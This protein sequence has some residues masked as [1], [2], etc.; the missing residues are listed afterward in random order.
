MVN[1]AVVGTGS[2]NDKH[3]EA[4]S[5]IP[6][7]NIVGVIDVAEENKQQ[8][9]EAFRSKVVDRLADLKSVHTD[10]VDLCVPAN[11]RADYVRQVSK[12]GYHIICEAPLALNVEE[13]SSVLKECQEKN[14]QIQIGHN[15]RFSPEYLDARNQVKSGKI[16]KPG[17][18]RLAS[19]TAHP[20]REFDIFSNLGIHQF[21][22][23]TWTFGDVERV[24]AK[25]IKKERHDGTL[26]EYALITLRMVDQTLA[27]IE[28]S[29]AA[30]ETE[31]SFELTGD[32]G[33]LTHNSNESYPIDVQLATSEIIE[34]S[35]L[36]KT[37][38]QRQMEYVVKSVEAQ[39]KTMV[40][41]D[42][43]LKAIRI[44]EA[45]RKSVEIGQPVLLKE[46]L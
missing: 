32:Q 36:D 9:P 14:V 29:W 19:G 24:M 20:G 25:H 17:V 28:L 23:L 42:D 37:A 12:E 34:E 7:V 18:M 15:L 5:R 3:L 10:I 44:A 33:M 22:W 46:V 1:V 4:W 2:C 27:H 41:G 8:L 40:T 21:D 31:T 11:D 35:I 39:D 38:L 13:A 45:A 16:G 30:T 43:A 6:N 26:I